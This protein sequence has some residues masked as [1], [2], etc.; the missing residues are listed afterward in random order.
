MQMVKMLKTVA[1]VNKPLIIGINL[2]S[3]D[4]FSGS[5]GF[6]TE[7]MVEVFIIGRTFMHIVG[8]TKVGVP[9]TV[10]IISFGS[11]VAN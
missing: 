3:D 1:K 10:P 8:T 4:V 7:L 11:I 5:T 6:L 2:R 9:L